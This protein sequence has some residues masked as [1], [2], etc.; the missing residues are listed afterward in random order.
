MVSLTT[1]PWILAV[2]RAF[3]CSPILLHVHRDSEVADTTGA[4]C[5]MCSRVYPTR[6]YNFGNESETTFG[7]S[8]TVTC[9]AES[10][11]SQLLFVLVRG[12]DHFPQHELP[13]HHVDYGSEYWVL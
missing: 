7:V 4:R 13:L 3:S 10:G 12:R 2:F 11:H 6:A 1:E 9:P 8:K 5:C